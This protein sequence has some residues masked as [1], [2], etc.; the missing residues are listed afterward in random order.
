[1]YIWQR[2]FD[3]R[4]WLSYIWSP[5]L[6]H[7]QR[8][9]KQTCPSLYQQIFTCYLFRLLHLCFSIWATRM[10]KRANY[11]PNETVQCHLCLP[12]HVE[13]LMYIHITLHPALLSCSFWPHH[14]LR[15]SH[16]RANKEYAQNRIPLHVLGYSDKLMHVPL[17]HSPFSFSYHPHCLTMRNPKWKKEWNL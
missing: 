10:L 17:L 13:I 1:M 12:I 4:K 7:I 6:G 15:R 2:I 9:V 5:I 3:P 11:T 16:P 8:R 14:F